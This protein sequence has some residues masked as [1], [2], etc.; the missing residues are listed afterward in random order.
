L[1][2]LLV[3]VVVAVVVVGLA[4]VNR[5]SAGGPAAPSVSPAPTTPAP[6]YAIAV[7]GNIPFGEQQLSAFSEN[8]EQ[9]NGDRDVQLVAHIGNVKDNNTKCAVNYYEAVRRDFDKVEDP[10]FFTPGENDWS[11]C[12]RPANG[13]YDPIDR[14]TELRKIFFPSPTRSLGQN[15]VDVASY[16]ADGF[17]ENRRFTSESMVFGTLH[18]VGADNG[19]TPWAGRSEAT[20]RQRAEIRV[21][22]QSAVKV[23]QDLFAAAS[24]R[25]GSTVVLL[26]QGNMF[27][28]ASGSVAQSDS[29]GYGP[30]V[31]AI[32]ELSAQFAGEVYLINGDTRDFEVDRPLAAGS[33]WLK[34]YAVERPLTNFTR[35]SLGGLQ[36]TNSYL[37]LSRDPSDPRYLVWT[38]VPFSG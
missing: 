17:P 26:T 34:R 28:A 37:K 32:A 29:Q 3:G 36:G 38:Q 7:I 33:P 22:T 2:G 21:R 6:A 4:L 11:T 12:H 13:R 19:A 31:R 15:R 10:L 1:V 23:V 14:L 16:A 27:K 24:E 18:L 20:N 9:I 5:P 8:V 25:R 30:V 35:L